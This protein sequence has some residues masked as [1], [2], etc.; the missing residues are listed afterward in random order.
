MK[1]N[2]L[3]IKGLYGVYDYDV[4]FN[5]DITFLYGING[6]GKTTVLNIVSSIVNGKL[7]ELFSYDFNSV[8]LIYASKYN[9]TRQII[10][11][12]LSKYDLEVHYDNQI[13]L[14]NNN[15]MMLDHDSFRRKK[16]EKLMYNYFDEYNFLKNINKEFNYIYLP[17]NRSVNNIDSD[18]S[19][20]GSFVI[21]EDIDENNKDESMK[22]VQYLVKNK[23]L[24]INEQ[25]NRLND[26]FRNQVLKSSLDTYKATL[27]VEKIFE[28]LTTMKVNE[29]QEIKNS[30]L[31]ILS[32]LDLINIRE[33][34]KYEAFFDQYIVKLNSLQTSRENS[35]YVDL[36]LQYNEIA[37]IKKIV[38]LAETMEINK[39]LELHPLE[40][41]CETLNEF[42]KADT[43][44]DKEIFIDSKGNV[45]FSTKASAHS[46]PINKLSSGEKQLVIFFA[47]LV[48]GV[49][50]NSQ[51][52]FIVDEPELSLHLTWQRLFVEK[53]LELNSNVQL[54]F[55][56]HSPEIIGPYRNKTNELKKVLR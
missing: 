35:V 45:R 16:Q 18:F 30:Y 55:A 6:S 24:K 28:Q 32:N 43:V 54:I 47:N 38:K 40:V 8:T 29:I 33:R 7:Y 13:H 42:L 37:K 19:S 48:F 41:F 56:T 22:K 12:K 44:E 21:D 46:L 3:S 36:I 34:E 25:I 49:K 52:I 1:I 51:A 39:R 27:N 17:L 15:Y 53:V 9:D 10:I 20:Y 5:K 4:K 23:V 26:D 14:I 11:N 2:K 31:R 50:E